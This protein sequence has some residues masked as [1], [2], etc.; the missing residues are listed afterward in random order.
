MSEECDTRR[1]WELMNPGKVYLPPGGHCHLMNALDPTNSDF[2]EATKACEKSIRYTP[3]EAYQIRER[4]APSS[5]LAVSGG[6]VWTSNECSPEYLHQKMM[7][8]EE[9]L[10]G[11]LR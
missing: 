9:G 4:L 2:L 11:K 8:K 10:L 6:A 5:T 3:Q 7:K 1:M